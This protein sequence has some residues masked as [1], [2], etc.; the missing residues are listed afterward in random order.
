MSKRSILKLVTGSY[1]EPEKE[2]MKAEELD[3]SI[4]EEDIPPPRAS[5]KEP[6][7]EEEG[8]LTID[9]Y[10][11]GDEMVIKSTIA[12]VSSADL[13]VNITN[14]MVSIKGKRSKEEDIDPENYYYQE[15]YWGSF[16]RSVILPQ[17]IDAENAKAALKDGVLTIR[18]PKLERSKSKKLKIQ[19]S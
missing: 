3:V 16:S 14:D 1:D 12:G 17:E 11:T 19:S 8:Q 5:S 2:D 9:V 4:Q 18:L 13:D 10:Q 15:L 6:W 7:T